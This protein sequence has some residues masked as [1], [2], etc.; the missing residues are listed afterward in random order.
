MIQ[1]AED[2]AEPMPEDVKAEEMV[3]AEHWDTVGVFV[4]GYYD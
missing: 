4:D 1:E 3:A 2:D